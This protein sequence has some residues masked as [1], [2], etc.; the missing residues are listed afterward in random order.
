M[1]A[2]IIKFFSMYYCTTYIFNKLHPSSLNIPIGKRIF[3]ALCLALLSYTIHLID[4][5]YIYL[6][7][8]LL[9]W[10]VTSALTRSPK[11]CFIASITSFCISYSFYII[12]SFPFTVILYSIFTQDNGFPYTLL[13]I[14]TSSGQ[15]TII[16]SLFMIKRLEKGLSI[17][18]ISP[19]SNII[20]I[21]GIFLSVFSIYII[22]ERSNTKLQLFALF[23]FPFAF[24]F[25]I[26]WWQAQITKSY[27][28]SLEQREMESL[29]TE[30]QEKNMTMIKVMEESER[31]HHIN[32]RDNSL[33]TTLDY[34]VMSILEMDFS[35]EAAVKD[36]CKELATEIH[37]A[38]DRRVTTVHTDV[39]PSTRYK[40]NIT[41]LDLLLNNTSKRALDEHVLFS[42]HV[43]ADLSSFIPGAITDD[44]LV[45][46]LSDLLENAFVATRD[47]GSRMIQLQFYRWNKHLVVEIADNGIP[48]EVDSILQ[49]GIERRTTHGDTGGTG[50]GLMD[51]WEIKEKYGATYHLDEYES[52]TPFTKKI[53]LTFDK[54]N[55]Y[56]VR[57]WRKND[58]LSR[59]KRIDLQVYGQNED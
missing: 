55:R 13:A 47:S 15:I 32:H 20:T 5:E 23:T 27:K 33:L 35:D 41:L 25:L 31:V 22:S 52:A 51:I 7:P 49:M 58:I 45:Y 43:R 39:V 34:A 2:H 42:V 30:L 8:L 17:F 44:D 10:Y 48:F 3:F 19:L 14:L 11:Q 16:S 24:A 46:L 18:F 50:V 21:L 9:F 37:R 1:I 54:K 36:R 59:S 29:R 53:S 12:L 40:T 57:T 6:V 4:R 26:Y 38:R 28:R 56:S